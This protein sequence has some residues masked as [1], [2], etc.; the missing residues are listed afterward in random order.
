MWYLLHMV[1]VTISITWHIN[2]YSHLS[3]LLMNVNHVMSIPWWSNQSYKF[4]LSQTSPDIL[5]AAKIP[6]TISSLSVIWTLWHLPLIDHCSFLK[7]STIG[8]CNS[9]RFWA[10]PYLSHPSFPASLVDSW[11]SSAGVLNPSIS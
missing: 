7:Y 4:S 2:N 9:T 8:F 5:K 1:D 11:S 10:S 6:W 3:S